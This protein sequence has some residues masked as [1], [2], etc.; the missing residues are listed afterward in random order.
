MVDFFLLSLFK[1]TQTGRIGWRFNVDGLADFIESRQ[2][3]GLKCTQPFQGESLLIH[4]AN[5]DYVR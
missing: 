4:G 2:I 5:S 3:Y 1:D